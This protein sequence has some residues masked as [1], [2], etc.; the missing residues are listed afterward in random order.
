MVTVLVLVAGVADDR[1][2]VAVIDRAVPA[3]RV[4]RFHWSTPKDPPVHVPDADD[5]MYGWLLVRLPDV[6]FRVTVICAPRFP[7]ALP[8]WSTRLTQTK[9]GVIPVARELP[10]AL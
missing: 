5:A 3:V 2:A 1:V 10:T 9:T 6:G 4:G 8:Y 7:A